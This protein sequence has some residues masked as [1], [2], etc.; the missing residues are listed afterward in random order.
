MI[1]GVPWLDH[2]RESFYPL[3]GESSSPLD[4]PRGYHFHPR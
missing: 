2:R 3:P 1:E 4:P